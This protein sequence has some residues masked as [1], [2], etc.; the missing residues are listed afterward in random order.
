M[1]YKIIS[2]CFISVMNRACQFWLKDI[3]FAVILSLDTES[4]FLQETRNTNIDAEADLGILVND[5][6]EEISGQPKKFTSD[7]CK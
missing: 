1:I 3:N 7:N 6:S 2:N 4:V 5:I